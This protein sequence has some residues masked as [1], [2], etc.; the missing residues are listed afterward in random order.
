MSGIQISGMLLSINMQLP[1]TKDMTGD[2]KKLSDAI[3]RFE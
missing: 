1:D 2:F 3:F